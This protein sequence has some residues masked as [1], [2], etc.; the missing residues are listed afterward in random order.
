[1]KKTKILS[2]VV[3]GLLIVGLVSAKLISNYGKVKANVGS[4]QSVLVDGKS[5]K[6]G[7][8]TIEDNTASMTAGEKQCFRHNLTNQAHVVATVR[9][10]NETI[11][12]TGDGA[13]ANVFYSTTE[14]IA[15]QLPQPLT[16]AIGEFFPFNI[17]YEFDIAI[18]P[19]NYNITT[20]IV[21]A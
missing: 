5:I 1:M 10:E 6:D 2:V 17:C 13:G 19:G 18:E 9:F 11:S 4:S 12:D 15:D 3:L 14:Y 21:P 16:L 20:S 7:A 8:L